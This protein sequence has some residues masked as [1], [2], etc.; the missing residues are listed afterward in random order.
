MLS[1]I[2]A[3]IRDEEIIS[4]EQES[5]MSEDKGG[6]VSPHR[7]I[8]PK[9]GMSRRPLLNGASLNTS[10]GGESSSCVVMTN[11]HSTLQDSVFDFG[12]DEEN[13]LDSSW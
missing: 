9:E 11:G 2:E 6:G 7:G 3:R 5:L 13:E 8:S 10:N 12:F 1:A 4:N